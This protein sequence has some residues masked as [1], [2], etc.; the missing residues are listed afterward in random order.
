MAGAKGSAIIECSCEH[1]YQDKKYGKKRRV[2]NNMANGQYR[3]SVCS[4][5]S[6]SIKIATETK[7]SK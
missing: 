6:G 4:K 3:C 7:K 2:F 5:V 1:E